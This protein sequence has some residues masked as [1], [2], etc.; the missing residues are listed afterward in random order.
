MSNKN[1]FQP[2][3]EESSD[4]GTRSTIDSVYESNTT[5]N[6]AIVE[7]PENCEGSV[8]YFLSAIRLTRII[9]GFDLSDMQM[10]SV[11]DLQDR[12]KR[13]K[14]IKHL[15][16]TFL[17][18][19]LKL[20]L[21]EEKTLITH[22]STQP[23]HFLGYE[24]IVQY[25]DDKRDHTNRRSING[26]VSLRVPVQVVIKSKC[27][28]YMREGKPHHR[29]ELLND[30]DFS[31]I[32]HYQSEYRGYVQYYLLAQNVSWLWKLHWI[33]R[34]SLLK[35]LAHKHKCSVTKMV[36]K[37]RASIET[38]Y[39]Q[40]KCLEKIVVREGKKPLVARFGGIP[41]RR[42]PLAHPQ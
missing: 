5:A 9:D 7:K 29:A 1:F 18:E 3:H 24:L 11:W 42:Q 12:R 23:A 20:E 37:Y 21:S 13:Q 19:Q 16:K 8:K 22:A 17:Q 32:A 15:L 39:G 2:S 14:H 30:D 38:P 28:L 4:N 34:S 31:I 41:L 10:I 33:M 36:R 25:Q 35:T 27:A 40:M 26:H 6:K